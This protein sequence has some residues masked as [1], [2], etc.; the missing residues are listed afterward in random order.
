[1]T[2]FPL[3]LACFSHFLTS[4]YHT[5]HTPYH[6]HYRFVSSG[7][8]CFSTRTHH[9]T[10]T[11]TDTHAHTH[12][13]LPLTV[14]LRVVWSKSNTRKNPRNM[15]EKGKV[16]GISGEGS[17]RYRRANRSSAGEVAK[18]HIEPSSSWFST[19][20]PSFSGKNE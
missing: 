15:P 8:P 18:D 16:R 12:A 7:F 17:F 9:T 2:I 1:M 20:F 5:T 13:H 19:R 11:L 14:I 3:F 4:Q 6:T 10:Y